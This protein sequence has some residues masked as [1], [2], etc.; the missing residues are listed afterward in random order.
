MASVYERRIAF[1]AKCLFWSMHAYEQKTQFDNK[2]LHRNDVNDEAMLQCDCVIFV[3][4]IVY[5]VTLARLGVCLLF[6]RDT[7]YEHV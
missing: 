4:K 6:G 7:H 1:A 2:T 5:S 3:Q